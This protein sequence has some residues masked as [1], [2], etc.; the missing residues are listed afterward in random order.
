MA[1]DKYEYTV[2]TD[3][4]DD[5]ID[6]MTRGVMPMVDDITFKE[7]ELRMHELASEVEDLDEDEEAALDALKSDVKD[8]QARVKENKRKATRRDVAI[9]TLT[10][11][12]KATLR[13]QMSS[14]FVRMKPSSYNVDEATDKAN[15]EYQILRK[16]ASKI[17]RCY[18]HADDWINAVK[19]LLELVKYDK[20]N[21]PW[22]SEEE[23]YKAF[24][25]GEIKLD[26]I[27]PILYLDY[28][29]P[30]KDPV[31]LVG[32]FN[33]EITIEDEPAYDVSAR[34]K[35]KDDTITMVPV[36]AY[37]D[38][39]SDY[40]QE[41]S[42][43]GYD[44][45]INVIFKESHSSLYERFMPVSKKKVDPTRVQSYLSYISGSSKIKDKKFEPYEMND[46]ISYI[47]HINND[48][49]NTALNTNATKWLSQMGSTQEIK[50]D[51]GFKTSDQL[52]NAE[53]AIR[54]ASIIANIKSL[55]R[56][57]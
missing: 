40:M 17:R 36:T 5:Y 31:T 43:K 25:S 23:Y 7:I 48:N 52:V 32:I 29:T 41:L 42:S 56:T 35:L 15:R 49:L 13:K 12:Q 6:K 8:I 38:A 33:G 10:E 30:I 9:F 20:R 45:P 14:S 53:A 54:E 18:Y 55:G 47:H 39:E 4:L 57:T 1:D 46:I 11:E 51:Y 34:P 19:T 50:V 44:T 24:W 16:R 21:Y 22:L 2:P 26:V 3:V 28:H 27:C 37:T